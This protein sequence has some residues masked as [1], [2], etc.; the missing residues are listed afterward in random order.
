MVC[1]RMIEAEPVEAEPVKQANNDS[2]FSKA[3][4]IRK[5]KSLMDEGIITQE[6]FDKKKKQLLGL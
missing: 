6:D 5:Y 4:E 2:S 1:R 3:D